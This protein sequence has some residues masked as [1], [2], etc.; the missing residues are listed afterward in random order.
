MTV[1]LT[2]HG[3][4]FGVLTMVMSESERRFDTN[5]LTL[6]EE[7]ARRS[8]LLIE[9]AR[10]Y[11][12]VQ[13]ANADLEARVTAR[14]MQLEAANKELEAFSYS[15]SHDLRAP[16]RAVSGFAKILQEDFQTVLPPDGVEYVDL[17][18]QNALQM[19]NL[20]DE[21]LR[22]SRLGRQN[23]VM[24]RVDMADLV[25]GVIEDL[26]A[27]AAT[28][29]DFAIGNLPPA[30][31]DA[32]LLKQVF[33]NL[34]GNA[35]KF[36]RN[37]PA[38]RVEI[39]SHQADG[40]QTVYYVKDNGAG[41][42]MRYVNKLFGV[43]QRLHLAEDYEGT[44]V[45]LAIVQRIVQRHGGRAWAEGELNKGATFYISLAQGGQNGSSG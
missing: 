37:S 1:P 21:L 45:G 15:V 29:P 4:T 30:W 20:I 39:D 7:L 9:G 5:D 10:L 3:Q 44:G 13:K 16:L 11:Q 31:G 14:T 12:E 43:F 36:S 42:D 22:F 18:R 23:L 2:A 33:A 34:I 27:G 25:R 40:G 35:I 38:P 6:A 41:F 24:H 19:G 8:A 26:C 17:I 32:V 28:R